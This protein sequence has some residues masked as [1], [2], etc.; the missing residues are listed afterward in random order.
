MKQISGNILDVTEGIIVQQ[1]NC[2]GV[3]GAGLAKQICQKYPSVYEHYSG[4]CGTADK[5]LLGAVCYVR[6]S[7]TL[8]VASV[9][10]Q[11]FYGRNPNIVYTDYDA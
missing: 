6:V 1:V 9:F 10:G 8:L 4:V 5:S 7:P 2:Q 11:E 3:M